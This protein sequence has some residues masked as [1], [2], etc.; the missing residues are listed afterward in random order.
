MEIRLALRPLISLGA[1][2]QLSGD[3][4]SAMRLDLLIKRFR[5][6]L[7]RSTKQPALNLAVDHGRHCDELSHWIAAPLLYSSISLNLAML[8]RMQ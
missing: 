1:V 4:F 5:Q 6:T 8:Q 2:G 7:Q 3:G